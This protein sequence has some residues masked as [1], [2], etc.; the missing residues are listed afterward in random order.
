MSVII[1]FNYSIHWRKNE[2][3]VSQVQ[4]CHLLSYENRIL[5]I[6]LSHCHY[7]LEYGKGQKIEYDLSALEKH[8]IDQF[9]HGKPLILL[10]VPQVVY[11]KDVYTAEAFAIIRKN[12]NPQVYPT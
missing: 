5:S 10:E 4:Y 3:P 6:V 8:I 2:I 7:S 9:V 1:L 12:V 11:R